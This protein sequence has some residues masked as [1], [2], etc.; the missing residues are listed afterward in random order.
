MRI[1]ELLERSF[2]RFMIRRAGNLSAELNGSV[3]REAIK[4]AGDFVSKCADM[5]RD[6]SFQEV[7]ELVDTAEKYRKEGVISAIPN[8]LSGF[9]LFVSI[10]S[11]FISI[12]ALSVSII[13][14]FLHK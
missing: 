12:A 2:L 13:P 11:L 14:F 1:F 5:G 10:S 3:N 6:L 8:V 7:S 4:H 9:S